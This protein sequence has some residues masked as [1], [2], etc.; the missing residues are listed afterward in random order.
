LFEHYLGNDQ[1]ILTATAL[2]ADESK[3]LAILK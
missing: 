1:A 2:L 3:Y